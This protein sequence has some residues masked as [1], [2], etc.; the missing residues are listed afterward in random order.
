MNRQQ[1]RRTSY[2][3][4]GRGPR[5]GHRYPAQVSARLWTPAFVGL[6]VANFCASMIFY[7]LVP[8]MTAYAM[9][10]FGVG[11]AAGGTLASIFFIGALAARLVSGG[12]FAQLG[13]RRMAT[14]AAVLYLASTAG[15]LVAPTYEVTLV[16]RFVN[17]LGFGLLSSALVSGILLTLP[18]HR[19]GEGAG[20]FGVSISLAIGLGPFVALSLTGGPWGMRGV[21]AAAT[22]SALLS[23]ALVLLAGRGLPER[24]P[25]APDQMGRPSGWGSLLDR[26]AVGAS[27]VVALGAVAYS[28]ILAFL[29]PATAG[30]HLAPAASAFFGVYAGVL[31]FSRPAAGRLQDRRGAQAVLVPATLLLIVGVALVASL[32]AGWLLLV[33]AAVLGLGFGT[34]TTATQAAVANR[35]PR[36]RTG[37][38]VATYFF[39][40][41]LGTGL[42]PIAL[43]LLVPAWGYQGAFA[44]AVGV[45]ALAAA[46]NAVQVVRARPGRSPA[47][48]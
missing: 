1:V 9:A 22:A 39:L 47:R 14:W 15:Y 8:T 18:L 26:R 32:A 13:A 27:V 12:V 20:F 17:G 5:P 35:V 48:P 36:E 2:R 25:A 4:A 38:A 3:D 37:A 19:R 46:A 30:T 41:D 45:A 23:L 43:G 31:L 34:M 10:A 16:V 7:L 29:G 28:V 21:F 24:A 33:G 42:G 44:A 40:L 6:A 11:P